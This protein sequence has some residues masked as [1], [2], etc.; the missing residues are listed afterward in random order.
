MAAMAGVLI[1]TATATTA[2]AALPSGP[3]TVPY[4][5]YFSPSVPWS[6]TWTVVE[7]VPMGTV[8]STLAES[9]RKCATVEGGASGR[10][11]HPSDR[12]YHNAILVR[13]P[14]GGSGATQMPSP[15]VVGT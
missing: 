4:L 5:G 14:A 6:G 12:S 1:V 10:R 2:Q 15:L 11:G 3:P 7:S 13:I 9:M 8:Q